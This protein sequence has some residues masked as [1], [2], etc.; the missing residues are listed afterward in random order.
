MIFARGDIQAVTV[1]EAMGGCG[2]PHQRPEGEN[3]WG[4]SCQCEDHLRT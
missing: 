4:I 3:A 1:S 2:Q